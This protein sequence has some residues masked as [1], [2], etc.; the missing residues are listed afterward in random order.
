MN[1]IF[2]DAGTKGYQAYLTAVRNWWGSTV[3][4]NMYNEDEQIASSAYVV[5]SALENAMQNLKYSGTH[6]IVPTTE[7]QREELLKLLKNKPEGKAELVLNPDLELPDYY[8]SVDFH[9][10]EGGTF[11]SP[12]SGFVYEY[13]SG[14]TTRM[15]DKSRDMHYRFTKEIK[16][17]TVDPN[18]VIVDVGCGF[19]KSTQAISNEFNDAEIYGV[20][21]SAPL[22]DLAHLRARQLDKRISYRQEN[23]TSTNFASGSV[24]TIGASMLIHEL[25][26]PAI[27]DFFQESRRILKKGGHLVCMDFYV[28]SDH[29]KDLKEALHLGHSSRN[30]EPYM[31]DLLEL[32]LPQVLSDAGFEVVKIEGVMQSDS[33]DEWALPWTFIVA[34]AA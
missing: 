6:G 12:V 3:F 5:F 23:C 30:N 15:V 25:A 17:V 32:D 16:Q 11:S 8:T 10:H 28:L 21:I 24:D 29:K 34:K 31:K 2:L 26:K 1:E 9:H 20:D 27:L 18:S 33:T 13:F 22:L 4:S 7:T 19:G 14:S